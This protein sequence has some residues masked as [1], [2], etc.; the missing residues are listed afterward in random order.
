MAKKVCAYRLPSGEV[1]G[2]GAKYGSIS[3]P[4]C[5]RHEG[6]RNKKRTAVSVTTTQ[7]PKR[8]KKRKQQVEKTRK[9][10]RKQKT[11]NSRKV[12][13]R[14]TRKKK[15]KKRAHTKAKISFY[16]VK[17]GKNVMVSRELCK[18]KRNKS[19]RGGDRIVCNYK[20]RK[21]STFVPRGF[22]L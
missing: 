1:C 17:T 18:I 10:R 4:R 22:E 16:D 9:P 8:K 6:K 19:A 3:A 20:G 7:G 12:A 14:K 2:K 11:P 15:G 13:T 5:K 21:Y